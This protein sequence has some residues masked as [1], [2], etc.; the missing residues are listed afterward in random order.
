VGVW[1]FNAWDPQ[2]VRKAEDFR[3]HLR[4]HFSKLVPHISLHV[5]KE[6][7]LNLKRCFMTTGV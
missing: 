1:S 4:K 6:K 5:Y 2:K 7:K 3:D